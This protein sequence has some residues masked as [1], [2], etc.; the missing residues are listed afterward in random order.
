M[1]LR[2]SAPINLPLKT[3]K[4]IQNSKINGSTLINAL[5]NITNN[6]SKFAFFTLIWDAGT[7]STVDTLCSNRGTQYIMRVCSAGLQNCCLRFGCKRIELMVIFDFNAVPLFC[8]SLTGASRYR[9]SD[10]FFMLTV[11]F[12]YPT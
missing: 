11:F 6:M 8:R 7:A 2:I 1:N 9:F 10:F 3:L 4:T 5:T 12:F